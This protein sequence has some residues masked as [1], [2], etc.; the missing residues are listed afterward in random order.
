LVLGRARFRRIK[1]FLRRYVVRGHVSSGTL[2]TRVYRTSPRDHAIHFENRLQVR[3]GGNTVAYTY[4]RINVRRIRETSHAHTRASPFH[5]SGPFDSTATVPNSLFRRLSPGRYRSIIVFRDATRVAVKKFNRF[6]SLAVRRLNAARVCSVRTFSGFRQRQP[7][8]LGEFFFSFN[9]QKRICRRRR[10][11]IY[12]YYAAS[13]ARFCP[14]R[15]LFPK[16]FYY[17]YRAFYRSR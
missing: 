3:P 11:R 14:G 15:R 2:F 8:L 13:R 7:L 12:I 4:E 1:R 9:S 6:F 16:D 5:R 17:S 10:V